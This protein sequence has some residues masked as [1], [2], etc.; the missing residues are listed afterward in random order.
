[1]SEHLDVPRSSDIS[2]VRVIE[3]PAD[4]MREMLVAGGCRDEKPREKSLQHCVV[5]TEKVVPTSLKSLAQ[6][7]RNSGCAQGL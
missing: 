2:G 1:M 3:E 5:S 4:H 6:K 7:A